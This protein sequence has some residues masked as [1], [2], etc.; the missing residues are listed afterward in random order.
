MSVA[1][2]GGRASGQ[3]EQRL[4]CGVFPGLTDLNAEA[5]GLGVLGFQVLGGTC[6]GL[7]D[8]F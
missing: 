3:G 7:R 1:M 5:F 2:L 8:L 4:T 6:R